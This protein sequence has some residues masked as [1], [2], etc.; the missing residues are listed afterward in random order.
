MK[1]YLVAAAL[2]AALV[3]LAGAAYALPES[4]GLAKGWPMGPGLSAAV[5]TSG[6][7]AATFDGTV[8]G[9]SLFVILK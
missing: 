3:A 5:V 4:Y 6:G 9:S 1:P 8:T 7:G 2:A